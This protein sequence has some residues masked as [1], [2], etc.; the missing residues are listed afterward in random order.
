MHQFTFIPGRLN[1]FSFFREIS[2]GMF[3]Y[4]QVETGGKEAIIVLRMER[5]SF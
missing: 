4:Q 1:Q 3:L 5:F 2:G